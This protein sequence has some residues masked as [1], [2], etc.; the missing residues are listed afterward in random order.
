MVFAGNRKPEQGSAHR[1]LLRIRQT[2]TIA[3]VLHLSESP[4]PSP[5]MPRHCS[6]FLF[7]L[8]CK[9]ALSFHFSFAAPA[10]KSA[11]E[12]ESFLKTVEKEA[13]RLGFSPTLVLNAPFDTDERREFA[14]RLT[15]GQRVESEKLK[16][17]VL[18]RKEQVFSHDPVHG[19]CRLI[20]ERG[21]VLAVTDEHR[22]EIVFGFLQYPKALMDVN[23]KKILD[24]EVGGDWRYQDFVDSP[25][26][27]YRAI[28]SK[29]A[30]AGYLK[31]FIDEF[32]R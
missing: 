9:M 4:N 15:T 16:G 10:T 13:K 26:P 1:Q 7:E 22:Q 31:E 5:K 14:R 24:T 25:D 20:P 28:V 19:G 29:F 12:L 3:N 6:I 17:V 30:E 11:A 2:A 23:G 27:R 21:V 18:V 32:A 8:L